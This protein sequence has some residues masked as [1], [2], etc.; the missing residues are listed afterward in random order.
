MWRLTGRDPL[1]RKRA[2][3]PG[4]TPYPDRYRDR[5]HFARMF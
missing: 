5:A 2:G 3:W 1:M 4:W